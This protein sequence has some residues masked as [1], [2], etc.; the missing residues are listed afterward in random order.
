MVN[1]TTIK[2]CKNCGAEFPVWRG[3]KNIYCSKDCHKE[4]IKKDWPT[5]SRKCKQCSK[6]F[7]TRI[8][9]QVF[10]SR[11]CSA[12]YNA[13]HCYSDASMLRTNNLS[14]GTVGAIAEL[15]VCSELMRNGFE[16]FRAVSPSS[17][18]DLLAVK[19]DNIYKIE[20]RTGRYSKSGRVFWPTRDSEGKSVIVVTHSDCK[21]HYITNPELQG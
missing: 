1:Y 19:G 14:T 15:V 21:I 8:A 16:V 11:K 2:H 18:S 7:K 20:V 4:F 17:N 10:C 13:I 9:K 5:H 12:K 3:K 6:D